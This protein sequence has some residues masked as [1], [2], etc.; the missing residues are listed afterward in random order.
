M[1]AIC[2]DPLGGVAVLYSITSDQSARAPTV[3]Y[4]TS[5]PR[6]CSVKMDAVGTCFGPRTVFPACEAHEGDAS[7]F[8]LKQL[9]G[10]IDRAN[11]SDET[12]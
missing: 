3:T 9:I 5:F 7:V 10:S 4:P 6:F 1:T 12:P 11:Q 2:D 8:R